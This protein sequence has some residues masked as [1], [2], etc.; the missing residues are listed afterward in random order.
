M[1]KTKK[2]LLL[3]ITALMS[4]MLLAACN[5]E[6]DNAAS[7]AKEGENVL[8]TIKDRDKIVFG[9][10]YD[11]KLFGLKDPSYRRS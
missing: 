10:K 5:S 8:E 2:F 4:V 1:F 3:T 6:D 11:T 9:V 7:D